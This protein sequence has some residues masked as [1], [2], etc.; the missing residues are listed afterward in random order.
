MGMRQPNQLT[1]RPVYG[2]PGVAVAS[3]QSSTF[4]SGVLPLLALV[5]GLAVAAVWFVGLP[6]LDEPPAGRSCEVVVLASGSTRCV[7][8]PGRAS[9]AARQTTRPPANAG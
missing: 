1:P 3:E 9:R 4:R 8:D 6:A 2:L 7:A 5:I